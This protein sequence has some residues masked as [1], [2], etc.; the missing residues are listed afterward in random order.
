MTWRTPN[1]FISGATWERAA[2]L[3]RIFRSGWHC[4]VAH[5]LT[6]RPFHLV[7]TRIVN[8]S[9]RSRCVYCGAD[10]PAARVNAH[11]VLCSSYATGDFSLLQTLTRRQRD[12]ELLR[13]GRALVKGKKWSKV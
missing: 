10:V 1:S 2:H 9:D 7:R 8:G 13:R 5:S 6:M 12:I 3:K 4:C 11:D